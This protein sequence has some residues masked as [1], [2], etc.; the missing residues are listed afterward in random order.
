MDLRE[1]NTTAEETERHEKIDDN[2]TR[3]DKGETVK[4]QE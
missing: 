4:S 1:E 3:R 2:D